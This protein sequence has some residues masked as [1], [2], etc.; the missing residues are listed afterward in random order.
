MKPHNDPN[1]AKS[2]EEASHAP[3]DQGL[4]T[5]IGAG[6]GALSGAAMGSSLGPLSFT[7]IALVLLHACNPYE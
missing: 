5:A 4:G 2:S 7:R 1:R 6:G 3:E